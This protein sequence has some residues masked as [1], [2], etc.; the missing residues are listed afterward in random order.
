MTQRAAPAQKKKHH[1]IPITYMTRFT[2]G[3][4]RIVAYQKD[5]PAKVLHLAPK[6]I[7]FQKYYYSQIRPDGE[8]DNH[9][10]EDLF[11]TFETDWPSVIDA[12]L[13]GRETGRHLEQLFN[14]VGLLRSR[15]PAARDMHERQLAHSVKRTAKLLEKWGRLPPP[16]AEIPNLLDLIEVA[17]DPQTSLHAMP[18]VMQA[19]AMIFERI[20][21]EVIHNESRDDFIT[22]DNPVVYFDPDVPEAAVQP[23]RIRRAGG[24]IEFFVP[25]TPR[26]LLRGSS[27]LLILRPGDQI[28]H[29][30]VTS[31]ASVRRIN[32]MTARFGYRLVFANTKGLEAFVARY[33]ALSPGIA[34]DT[35]PS[36]DGE[37]THM[38]MVFMPRLAKP[39]WNRG[40]DP[41]PEV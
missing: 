19:M 24:R 34:F 36:E 33:A 28:R 27:D 35:Y 17:I 20:G 18:V 37:L 7:A 30:R 10:L 12:L 16:P 32:R 26:L 23:Y 6:N 25:L 15:V 40:Q 29:M 1:F 39:Q 9:T 14:F 2:D 13:A 11:S 21:F 8:Q 41:G 5:T 3:D 4:G 22:S 31:S 38:Q